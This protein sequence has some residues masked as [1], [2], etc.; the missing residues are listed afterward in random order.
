MNVILQKLNA[1]LK[2]SRKWGP[3]DP[4][5]RYNWVQWHSKAK[6][7]ERDFTLK[8]RGTKDYTHSIKKYNNPQGKSYMQ[9]T[10]DLSVTPD[11]NAYHKN[12]QN[13]N[14]IRMSNR[15][16]T[17]AEVY[18]TGGNYSPNSVHLNGDASYN[19]PLRITSLVDSFE[20]PV[21]QIYE[22]GSGVNIAQHKTNI[23][24]LARLSRD[25]SV[26]GDVHM[27]NSNSEGYGTFRKGPYV[28]HDDTGHVCHRKFSQHEE[29]TEL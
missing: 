28:I 15:S 23:N 10:S 12:D 26:F 2:P 22:N 19:R 5:L 3:V 25:S 11:S 27:D 24:P 7:G 18:Y 21:I 16:S 9:T 6:E 14:N 1:V 13:Q 29:A 8:R 20:A 17:Y 4:I